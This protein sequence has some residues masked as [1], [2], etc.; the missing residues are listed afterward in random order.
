M[1]ATQT[2]IDED[3]HEA[4]VGLSL[5][6]LKKQFSDFA[7]VKTAEI[8]EARMSWRYYHTAQWTK[9][10]LDKL[11]ERGQPEITFD[12]VSRKIDGLVGIVQKLRTDPKGFP[13]TPQHAAGADLATAVLRYVLDASQWIDIE[14]DC[15]RSAGVHGVGV[16]E[17]GLAQGDEGDPDVTVAAVDSTTFFYDPRSLRP[18]FGDARYMG[19]SRFVS[20]S[21]LDEMFHGASETIDAD[22]GGDE[23]NFDADRAFLWTNARRKIRLVEHWYRYRGEWLYCI[24][25]ST[26][27]LARGPSPFV[28]EKR[29]TIPR[30]VA[31]SNNVDHDGDRYGFV[32]R[33]KGP[34]DAINQHRSKAIYIMNTRQIV[35]RRGSFGDIEKA[36][37]EIARPDGVIEFDGQPDDFRIEQG[38]QEFLQQTQ[39]FEDAKQEIENFGPSPALVDAKAQASSGRALAMLQQNGLAEIGPFL[40]N[41]RAWKMRVY[42][43][44]WNAV[45]THWQAER[46]IRVTD[47]EGMAQFIQVNALR[48]G[49]NGFPQM[50]NQLGALDVDIILDEGPDTVNVMGDVFDT[51]LSLAQN[52]APIPPQVII[53]LSPLPKATK[54]KILKMLSQ[55]DPSRAQA[56]QIELA[57][58]AAQVDETRAS[59][60]LKKAQAMKA[61]ADAGASGAQEA[62]QGPTMLEAS[63]TAARV[64]DL[65]AAAM[66]KGAQAAKI[67][68]EIALAPQRMA[69]EERARARPPQN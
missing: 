24:Y 49:Q 52:K 69:M 68:Q 12:R 27:E 41:Y 23:T 57:Q 14:R 65:G 64:R 67:A 13:R 22:D 56:M 32:R 25:T 40:G 21:E 29:R 31:W 18:D 8:D 42:R 66:L 59:A 9:E 3:E 43:A 1:L 61:L 44:V 19:V 34:Q 15:V 5:D 36:R 28:D 58:G 11:A 20:A 16:L 30:Y 63:E 26:T 55:P 39:Y 53:E 10:Q 45:R 4:D 37:R 7:S 48:L 2:A 6:A 33:L 46:F 47:D 17:L 62:P 51:I 38:A 60:G 35:A 54:D 50:V